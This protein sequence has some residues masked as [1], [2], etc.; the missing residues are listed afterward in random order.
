MAYQTFVNNTANKTFKTFKTFDLMLDET[1]FKICTTSREDAERFILAN[2]NTVLI[3]NTSSSSIE[4]AANKNTRPDIIARMTEVKKVVQSEIADES[5]TD[6]ETARRVLMEFRHD[7]VLPMVTVSFYSFVKTVSDGLLLN[8]GIR[9]TQIFSLDHFYSTI[10]S[11]KR[12]GPAFL[13]GDDK[14]ITYFQ[15]QRIPGHNFGVY[16]I[17]RKIPDAL[18]KECLVPGS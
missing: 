2:K 14:P 8:P 13:Y 1:E 17:I 3:R 12:F 15:P 4:F 16:A 5:E 11:I 7:N 6:A 9:H 10:E 18:I